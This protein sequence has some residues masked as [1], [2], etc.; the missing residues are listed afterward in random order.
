MVTQGQAQ[1]MKGYI[2]EIHPRIEAALSEVMPG[3]TRPCVA[4]FAR[5]CDTALSDGVER[6]MASIPAGMSSVQM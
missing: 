1:P 6:R 3:V 2:V 4:M 5:H